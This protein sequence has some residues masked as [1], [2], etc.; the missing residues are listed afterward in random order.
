MQRQG[1]AF[2]LGLLVA[3]LAAA[4]PP[5]DG[6]R[7]PPA[8]DLPG[9]VVSQNGGGKPV[10]KAAQ[11]RPKV[12]GVQA[13][14]PA[15]APRSL[16]AEPKAAGPAVTTEPVESTPAKPAIPVEGKTCPSTDKGCKTG[17]A[18]G[19]S[20]SCCSVAKI[21]EWLTFRSH[22]RQHGCYVPPYRPPLIAWF[23]CDPKCPPGQCAVIPPRP[24]APP[25]DAPLPPPSPATPTPKTPAATKT[26]TAPL[27]EPTPAP[28]VEDLPGAIRV[29]TGL[30][31]SPGAAPMAKP[32]TQLEKVSNWRPK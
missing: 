11:D 24:L 19:A 8:P 26:E 30:R 14:E 29:D 1:W 25:P 18:S 2:C 5:A 28:V 3:G 21:T 20:S 15:P 12:I 31:F 9:V 32:T 4:Q 27:P 22:A 13:D 23:T 6:E 7:Y 10:G 17:C 16:D